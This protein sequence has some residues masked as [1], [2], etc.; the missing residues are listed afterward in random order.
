[1]A[2]VSKR[3]SMAAG[4]GSEI[5]RQ[6]LPMR[7]AQRRWNDQLGH[8]AADHFRA[9]VAER[10]LRRWIEFNDPPAMIYGDDAV[11]HG[12]ENA[13]LA[14]LALDHLLLH[15]LSR[16]ELPHLGADGAEHL[17]QIGVGLPD[18]P[19]VEELEDA[20]QVAAD[21]HRTG[22]RAAQAL[23]GR[24]FEPREGGIVRNL[25]Q[26]RRGI[27]GPRARQAATQRSRAADAIEL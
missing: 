4:A 15:L 11:E 17:E 12:F 26:P 9:A 19:A 22:E 10:L 1:M 14:G 18:G 20:Q 23:G 7:R 13:G 5:S 16:E 6:A 2:V 21:G 27:A 25:D 8:L 3:R 24:G